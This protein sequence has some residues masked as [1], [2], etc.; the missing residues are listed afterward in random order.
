M[1]LHYLIVFPSFAAACWLLYG[2][3]LLVLNV[4]AKAMTQIKQDTAKREQAANDQVIET[5]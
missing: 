4:K 5:A 2:I 3:V 1:F